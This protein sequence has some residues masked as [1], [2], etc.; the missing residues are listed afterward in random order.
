MLPKSGW[1]S[2]VDLFQSAIEDVVDGL[3]QTGWKGR[4]GRKSVVFVAFEPAERS[5]QYNLIIGF[6]SATTRVYRDPW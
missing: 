4:L 5:G 3:K 6:L 1:E 2:H